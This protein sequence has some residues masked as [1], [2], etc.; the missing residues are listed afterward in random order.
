MGFSG[1]DY[2]TGRLST[3]NI[4]IRLFQHLIRFF[5]DKRQVGD[6][7]TAE[8]LALITLDRNRLQQQL[9]LPSHCARIACGLVDVISR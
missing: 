2:F 5:R 6:L 1:Q 4:L 8:I 7:R 3:G 9:Q